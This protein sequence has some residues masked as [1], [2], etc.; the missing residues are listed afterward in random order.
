MTCS[1]SRLRVGRANPNGNDWT[2]IYPWVGLI[3]GLKVYN[4][5]ASGITGINDAVGA[6]VPERFELSQNYPNPFNPSTEIHFV[7]P[8]AQQTTLVVYD[9]LGR[10]VRTVVNEELHAGEHLV[11][12]DGRNDRGH[13]AASGVY[14]YTL[15]SGYRVKT[16]KMML[17]K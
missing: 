8:K 4:Y 7:I 3:D 10:K 5:A 9:L 2:F 12:W 11:T 14:F 16:M 17:L 6:G 13:M 1:A 15:T